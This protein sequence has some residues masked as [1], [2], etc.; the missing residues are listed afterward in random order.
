MSD[1]DIKEIKKHLA[2]QSIDIERI[3]TALVGDPELK[4]KGIVQ[5]VEAHDRYIKKDQKLKWTLFG[6]GGIFTGII[7]YFYHKPH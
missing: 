7:E 4:S 1:A 6:A 2:K 5:Q 3:K